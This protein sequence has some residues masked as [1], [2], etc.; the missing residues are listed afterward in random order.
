M[1]STRSTPSPTSRAARSLVALQALCDLG[2]H[3]EVLVPA[4]L[5]ALHSVVPSSRNLF[6]WT[7]EQGRLVRYFIEGPIDAQIAQL[8]FDEFHN[9]R[10]AEVM[11]AFDSLRRSPAP[12]SRAASI[13]CT[14]RSL[15]AERVSRYT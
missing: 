8:Y 6:D 10:E 12:S 15:S 9:R 1:S 2:L 4:F 13:I 3:P 5:E 7:D 14:A 11:P